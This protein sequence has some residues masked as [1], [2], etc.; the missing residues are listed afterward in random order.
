[1]K[2]ASEYSVKRVVITSSIAAI[3]GIPYEDF[4]DK[5]DET[6]W[7]DLSWDGLKGAYK[8]SKTIA[9]LKSWNFLKELPDNAHKPEL[10]TICPGFILGPFI[11][12][13]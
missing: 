6:N 3:N 13:G 11:S 9:E 1:M 8:K 10:V 5:F 7:T 2:A 4:P 12:A